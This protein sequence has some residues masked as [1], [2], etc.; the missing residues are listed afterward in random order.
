MITKLKNLFNFKIFINFWLFN[1]SICINIFFII[2]FNNKLN[3]NYRIINS[4]FLT[5]EHIISI[6]L[7][8]YNKNSFNLKYFIYFIFTL[9]FYG[10]LFYRNFITNSK[11]DIIFYFIILFKFVAFILYFCNFINNIN[12]NNNNNNTYNNM[13]F[14]INTNTYNGHYNYI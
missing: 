7:F 9:T 14:D 2:L 13:Y 10:F 3:I 11:F 1:I 5:T 4:I 8:Y 6:I 12:I